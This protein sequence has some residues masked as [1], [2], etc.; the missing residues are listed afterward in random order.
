MGGLG[1][2]PPQQQQQQQQQQQSFNNGVVVGV[3]GDN[4]NPIQRQQDSALVSKFIGMLDNSD[5]DVLF[6]MLSVIRTHLNIGV[7][8]GQ[9]GGATSTCTAHAA[10]VFASFK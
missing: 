9:S 5:T 6:E 8:R 10:L 4:R 2:S 7:G 1:V 3:G